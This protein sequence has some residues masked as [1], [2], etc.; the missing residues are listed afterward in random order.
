MPR[1]TNRTL[2]VADFFLRENRTECNFIV[3]NI[4]KSL[5]LE[6]IMKSEKDYY[7]I[8]G[9]QR[10]ASFEEVRNAYRMYA[11]KFH[12]DKHDGDVFFEERFKEVKEAY[13]TLSDAEKRVK[14]D[15]KKFRK[16]KVKRGTNRE[17]FEI[18]RESEPKPKRKLR[19]DVS[20]IDL[21]IAFFYFINLT[22]GVMI[23]RTGE[24]VS[25]GR[26][27]W[28]LF[29]GIV[30]SFLVWLFVAGLIEWIK[31]KYSGNRLYLVGYLLLGLAVGYVTLWTTWAP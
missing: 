6:V 5:R 11:A 31:K 13:D 22:A 21:Y 3:A 15:I 23:K 16:S 25:P 10:D 30:S 28:G 7:Q 4:L 20:H 1:A 8:L 14:Y 2:G 29:F 17:D 18:T 9:I 27:V 26:L 12:P 24:N 19:V